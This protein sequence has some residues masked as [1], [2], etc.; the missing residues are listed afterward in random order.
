M[1]QN[2]FLKL[3]GKEVELFL[4]LDMRKSGAVFIKLKIIF[5]LVPPLPIDR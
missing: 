3:S 1:K 4:V 2:I 5:S